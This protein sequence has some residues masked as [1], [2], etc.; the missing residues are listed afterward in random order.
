MA[1]PTSY[2]LSPTPP[3]PAAAPLSAFARRIP[4]SSPVIQLTITVLPWPQGMIFPALPLSGQATEEPQTFLPAQNCG[5]WNKEPIRPSLDGFNV[6]IGSTDHNLSVEGD[7]LPVSMTPAISPTTTVASSPLATDPASLTTTP[8]STTV[9][10]PSTSS[11]VSSQSTG[12]SSGTIAGTAIGCLIAGALI[13]GLLFWLCWAKRG[14]SRARD[15]EASALAL[16]T[17]DKKPTTR[18]V[19]LESG[20]L[21]VPAPGGDLPQPLEDKTISGDISKICNSIKNHVQSYYHTGQVSPVLSEYDDIQALG[22][23]MPISVGTLSTLLRNSATREIAL[24]FCIAWVIISRLQSNTEQSNGLLPT[25]VAQCL[26]GIDNVEHG[27]KSHALLTAR[28]RTITAELMKS[29]YVRDPFTSSDSR[30]TSIR[31]AVTVLENV[32]QPY[33]DLRIDNDQ[34]KHNLEELIKR[35]ALFA[36]TL[37]S[38]PSSWDF[39]WKE[40]QGVKS[41]ELCIFPALVQVA[42]ESGELIRP[43]RPFGEAVIRRLG[44]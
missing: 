22:H 3:T 17:Y 29:A 44:V 36:F 40:E 18:V 21:M 37:F 23:N 38:Q 5:V 35:S 11:S 20:S 24:R 9:T 4:Y 41:G 34:R 2:V 8:T 27:S 6:K 15:S 28:W 19:S 1:C 32:L 13:A 26:H 31:A 14:K 39:D 43:P 12:I 30:N 10:S 25:E 33:A 7:P 42:D 16:T